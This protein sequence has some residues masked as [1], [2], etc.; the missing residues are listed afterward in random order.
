MVYIGFFCV[1]FSL[2]V[3]CVRGVMIDFLFINKLLYVFNNLYII[4]DVGLVSY[5]YIV[6]YDKKIFDL[7]GVLIRFI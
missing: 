4:Y 2:I 3:E 1:F 7:K 6:W 5:K